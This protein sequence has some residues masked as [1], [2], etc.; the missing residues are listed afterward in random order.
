MEPVTLVVDGTAHEGWTEISVS[1]ALDRAA[2]DFTLGLTDKRKGPEGASVPPRLY[3]G[4]QCRVYIGGDLVLTGYVDEVCVSYG[5]SDHSIKVTGRSRTC[6]L[7]DCSVDPAFSGGDGAGASGKANPVRGLFHKDGEI[8]RMVHG[9]PSPT[10]GLSAMTQAA[11]V[12]ATNA[13]GGHF[14]G[15]RLAQIA[16]ALARPYGIDVKTSGDSGEPFAGLTVEKGDKV[17]DVI[18]RMCRLRGLLASDDAYGHL[19]LARPGAGRSCGT[20]ELGKTILAADGRFSAK[21]RYSEYR[22][23]G[24]SPGLHRD[25]FGAVSDEDERADPDDDEDSEDEPSAAGPSVGAGRSAEI[26][27]RAQ[28]V[29]SAQ[30]VARDDSVTRYRL[31]VVQA[32][33]AAQA[34]G[35]QGRAQ[36]EAA[37]R[38]G[39]SLSL[40]YTAPGWRTADGALWQTNGVVWLIDPLMAL[41]RSLVIGGVDFSLNESGGMVT[42]LS[43]LPQEAYLPE[44]LKAKKP[45]SDG[46]RGSDGKAQSQGLFSARGPISR[47][48]SGQVSGQVSEEQ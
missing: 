45:K 21:E 40:T 17:F 48:V 4:A 36:W 7:V 11:G 47:Q 16:S 28:A 2:G 32:E 13:N 46:G 44:P 20:L 37:H 6:D 14:R 29:A 1:R 41:E 31:L 8:S 26:A 18:E 5:A 19:I 27:E 23:F 25:S 43:L 42:K 24:Q 22:V 33:T 35:A 12:A 3:C 15:Q 10:A 30:G 9:R 38:L 39:K 34:G